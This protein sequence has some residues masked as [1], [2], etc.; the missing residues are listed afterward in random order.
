MYVRNEASQ[1]R[2][3]GGRAYRVFEYRRT[4]GE[5]LKFVLLFFSV[6][7]YVLDVYLVCPIFL[8]HFSDTEE[9]L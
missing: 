8:E 7:V 9:P 6:V 3:A 1:Q 2:S 4:A 5:D